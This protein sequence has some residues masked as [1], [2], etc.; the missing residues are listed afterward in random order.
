MFGKN[1]QELSLEW[2]S[3]APDRVQAIIE[4]FETATEEEVGQFLI[5]W[6]GLSSD[7]RRPLLSLIIKHQSAQ[8]DEI[9]HKLVEEST[10]DLERCSY[11][12][13]LTLRGNLGAAES[14]LEMEAILGELNHL[15]QDVGKIL[16]HYILNNGLELAKALLEAGN[17]NK[18]RALAKHLK[19]IK[20]ANANAHLPAVDQLMT[21]IGRLSAVMLQSGTQEQRRTAIELLGISPII[22]PLWLTKA[23]REKHIYI[24]AMVMRI[25]NQH[26]HAHGYD[27]FPGASPETIG[28]LVLR[29]L[30]DPSPLVRE[31][32]VLCLKIAQVPDKIGFLKHMATSEFEVSK[33]RLAA[34]ST[35][36]ELLDP[37]QLQQLLVDLRDDSRFSVR[38]FARELEQDLLSHEDTEEVS[39]PWQ[40]LYS[41]TGYHHQV[42]R[43]LANWLE[44]SDLPP[45][46]RYEISIL[47]E[48]SQEVGTEYGVRQVLDF[49]GEWE[50]RFLQTGSYRQNVEKLSNL[51]QLLRIF[52]AQHIPILAHILAVEKDLH[53]RL[54]TIEAL[55]E[56]VLENVEVDLVKEVLFNHLLGTYNPPDQERTLSVLYVFPREA[57]VGLVVPFLSSPSPNVAVRAASM[58]SSFDLGQVSCYNSKRIV[59][60]I[61]RNVGERRAF[62]K[63]WADLSVYT[64]RIC[65]HDKCGRDHMNVYLKD[66]DYMIHRFAREVDHHITKMQVDQ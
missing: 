33:V 4:K 65:T 38:L 64:A 42:D 17:V 31:K 43:I 23:F 19:R 2:P 9:L 51:R 32:A 7:V 16:Y 24:R 22:L 40:L 27:S 8:V 39:W 11:L 1:V 14:L 56:L 66:S 18:I 57:Y 5:E 61:M 63:F 34:I 20:A 6:Q 13:A 37:M 60:Q 36:S 62:G 29:G 15:G 47:Q 10:T 41:D 55:S 50:E 21:E 53:L 25:I 12:G 45:E 26:L 44:Q 3:L 58:L 35:L 52:N 49:Y 46:E 30:Q 48:L 59:D 28:K 54:A